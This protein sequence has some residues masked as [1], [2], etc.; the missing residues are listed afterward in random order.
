MTAGRL[1]LLAEP[2]IQKEGDTAKL[3][4]TGL[5]PLLAEYGVKLG[6]NRIISFPPRT[7]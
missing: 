5:E 4:P 7:R 2:F 1:M 6:M 3:V